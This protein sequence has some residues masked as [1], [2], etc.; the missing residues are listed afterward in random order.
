[1]PT[2]TI[3]NP[4]SGAVF[5]APANVGITA[6]ASV[7][8]GSVTNVAFFANTNSLGSVQSVPFSITTGSLAVG[9]YALTAVAT[10]A[11]ILA[12]SS[13]VNITV[14]SPVPITLSSPTIANNQFA[15][16]YSA[17]PGL[18]YVVQNSSNLI[19]WLSLVTNVPS[20]NSVHFAD[21]FVPNGA[22]YYRVGRMP[23][24]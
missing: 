23:N 19:N 15:F 16:D 11:G 2:V 17:N 18:N 1:M 9:P 5:A 20:S 12:T 10:A 8:G 24:P 4:A 7:A 13:V 22:R 21:G 6:S 14:V 3:T